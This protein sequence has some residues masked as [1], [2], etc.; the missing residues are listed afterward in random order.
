VFAYAKDKTQKSLSLD[1]A[2]GLWEL[3]LPPHF[4]LLP[5]WLRFV[6]THSRN[7][8]SK[9]LWMQVLEFGS[10]VQHDLSNFDE[11][12]AWPVLIDDF[13][14]HLQERIAAEGLAAVLKH[15]SDDGDAVMEDA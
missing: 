2:L 12:G 15:Q 3:L 14:T 1:I 9:D 8:V 6:K 4:P 11:N 5:H 10:Q 13:V 7:S